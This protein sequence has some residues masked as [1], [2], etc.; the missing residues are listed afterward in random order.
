MNKI[1]IDELCYQSYPCKHYCTINNIKRL[2]DGV[3]IEQILR[4]NNMTDTKI[5]NH[6][7]NYRKDK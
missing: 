6:F 7:K 5:Y 1:E 4:E 3:K 2:T